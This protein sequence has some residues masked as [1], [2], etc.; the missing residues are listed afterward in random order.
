SSSFNGR[1]SRRAR[2]RAMRGCSTEHMDDRTYVAQALFDRLIERN[3]DFCVLG[4]TQ[5]YPEEIMS[6]LDIAVPPRELERMPRTLTEFCHDLGLRLVQLIRHERTASYFVIAWWD[7]VGG[8]RFLAPDVC[9]DYCRSG[10]RVLGADELLSRRQTALSASGEPR[11]FY[12]PAPD[13]Q[14]IYY[15]TKKIDKLELR[16][17]HGA[18]LSRQWQADPDG[19]L[20]RMVRF[21][22]ELADN[23]LIA[24]AATVNEWAGVRAALPQLRAAL[25]RTLEFSPLHAAAESGRRL[26]RVLRPTGMTVAF[27]GPDGSGKSSLIERVTSDLAPAFRRT[28]LFHLRPRLLAPGHAAAAVDPHAA[29]PRGAAASL[30]KLAWFVADYLVGYALRVRPIAAR[31][32]LVIFD[33][34]FHDLVADPKRYRYGASVRM[35]RAAAWFV[36]EP[37]LW[38]ILD[39][40]AA[41]LQSRKQ[42]VSAVESEQQRRAYLALAA[43]VGNAVVIDA[44]RS[45]AVVATEVEQA[46]LAWLENRVERRHVPAFPENPLGARVLLFCCR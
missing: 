13:V 46:I 2:S 8:L 41:V 31:S 11:D 4:D 27:M 12:V 43:Q 39:A 44:G 45:P 21:W 40:S 19:A 17:G 14:F 9:S 16:A 32:G 23:G 10:R 5:H 28:E 15:L 1:T 24:Q 7:G 29:P 20:R 42:E 25:R 37:D 38:V 36:P 22:P 26:G 6:D 3:I 34:Y 33:R 35:A 30:A 18:Y